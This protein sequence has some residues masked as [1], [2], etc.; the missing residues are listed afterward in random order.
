MSSCIAVTDRG[1]IVPSN[2]KIHLGRSR[3]RHLFYFGMYVLYR[4][5]LFGY[6]MSHKIH[7][8]R[9]RVIVFESPYNSFVL[10]EV[11]LKMAIKSLAVSSSTGIGYPCQAAEYQE[12][13]PFHNQHF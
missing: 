12:Y 5:R 7:A 10:L 9:C 11:D 6:P 3:D 8:C 4:R 13:G 2:S 1:S